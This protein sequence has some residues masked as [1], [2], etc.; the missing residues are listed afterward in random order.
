M[1]GRQGQRFLGRSLRFCHQPGIWKQRDGPNDLSH[2]VPASGLGIRLAFTSEVFPVQV[3]VDIQGRST[4]KT[5][6]MPKCR[7]GVS[8]A[9]AWE[10]CSA[11]AS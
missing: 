10:M 3:G 8:E 1:A 9:E 7:A 5:I 11:L 4:E 2:T 6:S